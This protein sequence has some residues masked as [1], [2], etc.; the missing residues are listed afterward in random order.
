VSSL[1]HSFTQPRSWAELFWLADGNWKSPLGIFS[2]LKGARALKTSLSVTIMAFSVTSLVA[3]V[4]PIVLS[5]AYPVGTVIVP[6]YSEFNPVIFSPS[7]LSY[8]DAY[9]QMAIGLGGWT[10][11]QTVQGLYNSSIYQPSSSLDGPGKFYSG[12]VGDREARVPGLLFDG[13]CTSLPPSF[14][15][16]IVN[17]PEQF[18][19]TFDSFCSNAVSSPGARQFSGLFVSNGEAY[20]TL[21]Y[22]SSTDYFTPLVMDNTTQLTTTTSAY[23][24]LNTST[25]STAVA[26]LFNCTSSISAGAAN[27]SGPLGTYSSYQPSPVH[28]VLGDEQPM[29]PMM[30][31]LYNIVKLPSVVDQVSAS[32]VQA[33]GLVTAN[34]LTSDG[35]EVYYQPTLDELARN[36]GSGIEHTAAGTMLLAQTQNTTYNSTQRVPTTGRTRNVPFVRGAIVL[37]VLWFVFLVLATAALGRRTFGDGLSSYVTARLFVGMGELVE[38]QSCGDMSVSVLVR[39][40][41]RVEC[42]RR[43]F[44][45]RTH[46]WGQPFP[47]WETELPTV[48]RAS[49]NLAAGAR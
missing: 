41:A 2:A 7:A 24:F 46:V 36:L 12:I 10:T 16:N 28:F 26:G 27:V 49:L 6:V 39:S 17:T 44:D 23:I 33:L 48:S 29:D 22:C 45:R 19:I 38:G 37:I 32:V 35:D 8:G 9:V 40:F 18:N 47:P 21:S 34:T 4:T 13:G 31:F 5:H 20:A 15:H 25:P 30:A 11:G 42:L 3:L 43:L 14:S 1:Q